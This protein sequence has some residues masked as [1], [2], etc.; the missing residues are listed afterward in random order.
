LTQTIA[1]KIFVFRHAQTTD[2]QD[3]IFSG[4]RDPDL[5]LLGQRQALKIAQQLENQ[6]IKYAFTSHLK[7][8][9]STLDFVLKNHPQAK[10]FTDDRLIERC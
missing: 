7:R 10:I 5:T 8:A 6:N 3:H 1:C 9:K 4:W 2:N